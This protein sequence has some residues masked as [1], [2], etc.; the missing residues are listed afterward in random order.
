MK[1][2]S[3]TIL[4]LTGIAIGTI[5]GLLIAPDEGVRTRKKWMK[6]AKKYKKAVGD[7]ASDYK[8]KA[9]DLKDSIENA[10]HDI[11]KRFS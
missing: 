8:E 3:A 6:K 10:A 5:T 4:L 9:V 11:K 2:K 1:M 7:K